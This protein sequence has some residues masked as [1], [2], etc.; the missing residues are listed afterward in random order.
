MIKAV[1]LI[2]E[3]D[4]NGAIKYIAYQYQLVSME[5]VS[6]RLYSD[7]YPCHRKASEYKR[8]DTDSI[9]TTYP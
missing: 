3:T 7:A 4:R 9:G 2:T 8:K 6:L 1:C 5:S